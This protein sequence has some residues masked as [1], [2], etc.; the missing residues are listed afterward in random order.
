MCSYINFS[1]CVCV[2]ACDTH[3]PLNCKDWDRDLSCPGHVLEYNS[4]IS[5][6]W[7]HIPPDPLEKGPHSFLWPP[8]SQGQPWTL[9]LGVAIWDPSPWPLPTSLSHHLLYFSLESADLWGPDTPFARA[10]WSF[11][12]HQPVTLPHPL[13]WGLLADSPALVVFC[14]VT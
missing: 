7:V 9:C 12:T 8:E 10:L 4:P 11:A 2:F 1:V 14:T 5:F 13:C 6:F 3:I